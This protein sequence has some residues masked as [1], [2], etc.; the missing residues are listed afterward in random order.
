MNLLTCS[1][2][3]VLHQICARVG[4]DLRHVLF[5]NFLIYQLSLCK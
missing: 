5:T 4:R 1:E 3:Y 2:L